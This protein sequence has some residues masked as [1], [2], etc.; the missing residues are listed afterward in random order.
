MPAPAENPYEPGLTV[1]YKPGDPAPEGMWTWTFTLPGGVHYS[2]QW[3]PGAEPAVWRFEGKEMPHGEVVTEA[4]D[5]RRVLMSALKSLTEAYS[6]AENEPV[7]KA[8]QEDEAWRRGIRT[9]WE[10]RDRAGGGPLFTLL[11]AQGW[12]SAQQLLLEASGG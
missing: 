9:G 4:R 5:L 6:P 8:G 1:H 11:S 7:T 3:E 2:V 12:E 10:L